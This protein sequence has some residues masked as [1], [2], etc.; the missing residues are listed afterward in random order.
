MGFS[1]AHAERGLKLKKN[2]Q[3]A[4]LWCAMNPDPSKKGNKS[5]SSSSKD[6]KYST[7]SSKITKAKPRLSPNMQARVDLESS[8]SAEKK[9]AR[10]EKYKALEEQIDKQTKQAGSKKM[11]TKKNPKILAIN[12]KR[13]KELGDKAKFDTKSWDATKRESSKK[14]KEIM[15]RTARRKEEELKIK[16]LDAALKHLQENYPPERVTE[17]L[18]LILKIVKKVLKEPNELKYRKINL[19]NKRIQKAIV[20]PLGSMII[21]KEFGFTQKDESTLIMSTGSTASF[22]SKLEKLER[23]LDRSATRVPM[24]L[25]K[26]E[27][28]GA[29]KESILYCCLELKRILTSIAE[30]PSS[31]PLRSLTTEQGSIYSFRFAPFPQI[32]SMLKYLGFEST[33]GRRFIRMNKPDV[34]LIWDAL[35]DLD[36]QIQ[37]RKPLTGVAHAVAELLNKRGKSDSTY[38]IDKVRVCLTRVASANEAR[39]REIDVK[40]LFKS[41]AAV[42]PE[43]Q[44]LFNSLGFVEG[45]DGKVKINGADTNGA[46]HS[47]QHLIEMW[48]GAL[49][50]M[51]Q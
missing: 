33:E 20:R 34:A 11:D 19:L 45:D 9:A 12:M 23:A 29:S 37:K 30:L 47:L 14:N 35:K 41:R 31:V 40:R 1:R 25:Q 5:H 22:K 48:K 42:L 36:K 8:D 10:M 15:E 2:K 21:M 38:V 24:F 26:A 13:K 44:K 32:V 18:T 51:T 43:A 39:N 3:D 17:T 50:V 7:V 28:Q 49:T 6:A 27:T 46:Y 4:A 16:G